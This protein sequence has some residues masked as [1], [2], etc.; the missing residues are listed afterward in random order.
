MENSFDSSKELAAAALHEPDLEGDVTCDD[1][2]KGLR[3]A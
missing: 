1:L 3:G 2:E